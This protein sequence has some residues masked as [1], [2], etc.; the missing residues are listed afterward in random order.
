VPG[1]DHCFVG[2]DVVPL[3]DHAVAFLERTLRRGSRTR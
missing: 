3:V 2:V 1:A